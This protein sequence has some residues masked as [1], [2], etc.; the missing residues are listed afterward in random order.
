MLLCTV[1]WTRCGRPRTH[2]LKPLIIVSMN[3]PRIEQPQH[4]KHISRR[5]KAFPTLMHSLMKVRRPCIWL[6]ARG[7]WE[8]LQT[9][10][11]H[12]AHW[13]TPCT[14]WSITCI[15][16]AFAFDENKQAEAV[17]CLVAAGAHVN[18]LAS[19]ATP[20]PHHPFILPPGTALH[21]AVAARS[22]TVIG[23]LLQNGVDVTLRDGC[24]V[25]VYDDRIRILDKFGGPDMEAYSIPKGGVKGLSAPDYAAM[26]QDPFILDTIFRLG[27]PMMS[28]RRV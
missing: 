2:P 14:R 18:A 7:S 15:H 4:S 3:S 19:D 5:R 12:G 10:F 20:F 17:F 9:H 13:R 28:M 25:Y 6:G 24:D 23:S 26:D 16:W 22:Y 27:L 11:G 21:Q 8:I 1:P